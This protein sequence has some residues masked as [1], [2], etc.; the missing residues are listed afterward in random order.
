MFNPAEARDKTGRWYKF[1]LIHKSDLSSGDGRRSP[2][3]TPKQFEAYAQRGQMKL[4]ALRKGETHA[5]ALDG[6]AWAKIKGDAYDAS[7]EKWGGVT[8]DTHTGEHVP[9]DADKYALTVREPGMESVHVKPNATREEFDH[10]MDVAKNRYGAIL[11]RPDHHIGVFHDADTNSIDIDPVYI[12]NS[13]DDVHDIGAYTRAVGGAYHF[14]SGLGFWPPHVANAPVGPN[15]GD[16]LIANKRGD[17]GLSTFNTPSLR[18]E[19]F[20]LSQQDGKL[21]FWKQILPMKTINYT[22]KDGSRQKIDFTREYLT[23]LANNKAVDK[24]GFLLADKDNAHT[25]DPE[26]WRGDVVQWEVRD[27][28]LSG[29]IVFPSQ[30]AAAAA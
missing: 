21:S 24:I 11:K 20:D 10:A 26:R 22:A 5:S 4:A 25:M 8:V 23:D 17:Y 2:E 6:P 27:D 14:K 29:K 13:L 1:P 19:D 16:D 9:S 18:T 30:E 28:G 15:L 12:T 3:V 7:R